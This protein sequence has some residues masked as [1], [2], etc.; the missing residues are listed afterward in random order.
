MASTSAKIATNGEMVHLLCQRFMSEENVQ[1]AAYCMR[2]IFFVL[3]FLFNA[4]MWTLFV[5]AL[6]Y[7][8]STVEATVTNTASNFFFTAVVSSVLFGEHLSLLWWL[9]SVIILLGLLL[10]HRG[11]A[12]DTTESKIEKTD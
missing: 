11:S 2:V 7:C 8:S 5:K 3:I 4:L 1:M 12:V 10:I 6:Q 9:G